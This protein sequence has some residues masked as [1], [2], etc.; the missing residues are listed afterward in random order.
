M[1]LCVF[2]TTNSPF[3]LF[4]VI[5]SFVDII[6]H[7]ADFKQDISVFKL[8]KQDM[9]KHSMLPRQVL[10]PDGIKKVWFPFQVSIEG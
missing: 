5:W 7:T 8:C 9:T 1:I 3:T 6:L 4:I 2:V 10:I